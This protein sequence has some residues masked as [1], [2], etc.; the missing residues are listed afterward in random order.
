MT[1]SAELRIQFAR[2]YQPLG[3]EFFQSLAEENRANLSQPE[4]PIDDYLISADQ[5]LEEIKHHAHHSLQYQLLKQLNQQVGLNLFHRSYYSMSD[6]T[7]Y[8]N[9]WKYWASN[10]N[11]TAK[12]DYLWDHVFI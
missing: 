6:S 2:N 1:G 5:K 12:F 8:L 9:L 4:I 11:L 10:H 3:S 7:R